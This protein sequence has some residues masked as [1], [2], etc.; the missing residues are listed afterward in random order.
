LRTRKIEEYIIAEAKKAG[1]IKAVPVKIQKNPNRWAKHLAPWFEE[2]C[3][4][5][6]QKY[7]RLKRAHGKKHAV[8]KAAYHEYKTT[9]KK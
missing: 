2:Q 1:V 5:A 8:V 7:R 3:K 9:C 4:T 6:R